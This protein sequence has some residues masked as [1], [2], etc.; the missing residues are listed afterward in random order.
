MNGHRVKVDSPLNAKIFPPAPRAAS[1]AG[2]QSAE[3]LLPQRLLSLNK[4]SKEAEF[5]ANSQLATPT[6]NVDEKI[7]FGNLTG[8]AWM[9]FG[10]CCGGRHYH[11]EKLKN[12]RD[13][14]LQFVLRVVQ[15]PTSR[16]IREQQRRRTISLLSARQFLGRSANEPRT[17]LGPSALVLQLVACHR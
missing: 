12:L 15:M 17:Q 16:R 1:P 6:C 13:Q 4:A 10:K 3:L 7:G 5:P 8:T 14:M 9:T 11:S 2:L